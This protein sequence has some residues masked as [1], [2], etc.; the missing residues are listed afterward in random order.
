[1]T[2]SAFVR[3]DPLQ[4]T[5][6]RRGIVSS[7]VALLLRSAEI[8]PTSQDHLWVWSPLQIPVVVHVEGGYS[9]GLCRRQVQSRRLAAVSIPTA[10]VPS[11]P[12]LIIARVAQW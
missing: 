2:I 12:S 4:T 7:R 6:T 1:M 10:P 11:P 3:L 9:K 5:E 8:Q